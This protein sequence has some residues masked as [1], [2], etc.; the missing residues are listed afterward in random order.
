MSDAHR[1]LGRLAPLRVWAV[2]LLLAEVAGACRQT[3]TPSETPPALPAATPTAPERGWLRRTLGGGGGQAGI[4]FDPANPQVVY[5]TTDNGGLIKSLDGGRSWFPINNNI[6][7][8]MLGDSLLDPLDSQVLYVVAEVYT[9]SPSD[10]PDPVNGELYRTRNGGQT[11]EIVYAEG[12]G[13]E[14]GGDGRAFGISVW[15]STRSLYIPY[16]PAQPDRYDADGNRLSD[17]I[18]VGGWDR[19][20][21][22]PDKRAGLWKSEDEGRTFRQIALADQN[23]WALRVDPLE[24]HRF[25]VA[26]YG[27]GL[28]F[29]PDAGLT[30]ESWR[31]RLPNP[32]VSD[33]V[34]DSS[35]Q[36][37]YV[38]TNL[39]FSEYNTAEYQATRGIYKSVDGGRTF[40][41]INT[42]L[43][44]TGFGYTTLLQDVRDPTGQTLY[45]GPFYGDW[46]GIYRTVDGGAHWSPMDLEVTSEPEWLET[47]SNLWD[48]S[49]AVDGTLI[50]T[51]WRGIYRLPPGGQ[52]W[53]LA[54]QG[55]GNIGVEAVKFEPGSDS[56][57]YLGILDALPFKS[58]DR[59]ASWFQV[60][61]GFVTAQGSE[62]VGAAEFAVSP[63]APQIVYATG[64][65]ASGGF[66]SAVNKSTDGGLTWHRIVNGLPSSPDQDPRWKA[67]GLTVTAYDPQIA[68]VAL[69]FQ[70]G[71]AVYKTING[72]A[73]WIEV[74]R[75]PQGV[76]ALALSSSRPERVAAATVRGQIF[77]SDNTGTNWRSSSVERNLIYAAAIAPTNPDYIL[78]GV[79]IAG[80]YLSTDGGRNWQHVFDRAD[81]RPF[82]PERALSDFARERYW[83]T[84]SAAMF[85][86]ADE[87]TLYLG[88]YPSQW[89]GLG[90]LQ[91]TD[92]GSTWSLFADP[93]FQMRS[94]SSF[95]LAPLSRNWVVGSWEVYYYTS[96][97]P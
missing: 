39:F 74:L 6:G 70:G 30:W 63:A 32:M 93:Q 56:V 85:D 77:V 92:A 67:T 78:L 13:R 58:V 50:A 84:M 31:E 38:T 86:P 5:V 18:Y 68:Y 14:A 3:P 49:Q 55:L 29:S 36:T 27:D 65:G 62:P 2:L 59:G 25:Y 43:D 97:V 72:G 4:S 73:A 89:M 57:I 95:D 91:S 51:S 87:H 46:Q 20:P 9:R 82:L 47:F 17:V 64:I 96:G 11:W 7:S 66:K 21:P 69:E 28:W 94:V 10:R 22:N 35:R 42:G 26:T 34:I 76:S 53:E 8:R 16:D 15:P 1:A 19:N 81:L 83:P 88:H 61:A 24:P 41:P 45:T 40:F 79:N 33:V 75:L 44:P 80:A 48:I 71:G 37:L 12:M 52:R 60:G 23:V 90:V 54:V